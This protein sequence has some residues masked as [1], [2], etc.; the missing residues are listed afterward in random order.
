M[1]R[2]N[3][4]QEISKMKFV[5]CGNC[6]QISFHFRIKLLLDDDATRTCLMINS[7]DEKEE[8]MSSRQLIAI[9]SFD[10][11]VHSFCQ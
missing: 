8:K 10:V 7:D 4:K 6:H 1:Q 2:G 3:D 11:L 9:T 5:L